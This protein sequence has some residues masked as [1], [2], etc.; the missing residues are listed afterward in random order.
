MQPI[1][2]SFSRL[3]WRMLA[4]SAA[5]IQYNWPAGSQPLASR[6]CSSAGVSASNGWPGGWLA[7]G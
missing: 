5:T 6:K 1:A 3:L 2:A 7:N 4:G